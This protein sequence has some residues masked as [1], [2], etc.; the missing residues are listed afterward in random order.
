MLITSARRHQGYS[1]SHYFEIQF[2]YT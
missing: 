1:C 2:D